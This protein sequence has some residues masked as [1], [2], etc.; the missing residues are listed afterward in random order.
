MGC[1]GLLQSGDLSDPRIEPISHVSCTG[2]QVLYHWCH[3]GSPIRW[4]FESESRSVVSD[5]LW[6]HGLCNPWILQARILEWVAVPFSRGS[7]QPRNQTRVSCIADRFFTNWAIREAPIVRELLT[8]VRGTAALEMEVYSETICFLQ[9]EG[10]WQWAFEEKGKRIQRGTWHRALVQVFFAPDLFISEYPL[11][12]CLLR[13]ESFC[14]TLAISQ[15]E[16]P[17]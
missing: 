11:L 10:S 17:C 4:K 16:D 12:N 15:G 6:P 7:S 3:L 2:R 5:S 9:R 13:H 14:A 8:N 1:H